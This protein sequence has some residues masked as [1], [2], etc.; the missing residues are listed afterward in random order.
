MEINSLVRFLC[1]V[2]VFASTTI[3][4]GAETRPATNTPN[5]YRMGQLDEAKKRA[6]AEGKPIAWIASFPEYL[7]PDPNPRKSGSHAGTTYAILALQ[8]ETIIIFSDA[9]AENHNE[10]AIVNDAL[11]TP[12]PHYTVPGV[13]ILTPSLDTVITKV[14]HT[15]N[16]DERIRRFTDV[17][18]KIRDKDSWA[19]KPSR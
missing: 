13:I 11:H 14:F 7:T 2:A 1:L 16:I 10:P 6:A 5:I 8:K 15:Q 9:R 12:E 4:R 19:N 18:K 3:I 17:L